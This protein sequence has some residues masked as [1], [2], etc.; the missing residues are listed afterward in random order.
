M[1]DSDSTVLYERRDAVAIITMNRPQQRNAMNAAMCE[2][3]RQ[4]LQRFEEDAGARAAVLTGAGE[5][6]FCAGLDL[7]AYAAGEGPAIIEGPGGFGGL[8]RGQPAKPVVAAVNGAAVGGGLELVLACDLAVAAANA[9]FSSPEVT[10]GLF[11]AAGGAFRLVRAVGRARAME[12]LLTGLTIDARQ[13][14]EWGLVNT[15]VPPTRLVGTA[16]SLAGRAGSGAP[17]GVAETLKLARAAFDRDEE[18]LWAMSDQGWRRVADSEDAAEGPRAF[19]EKREP[20]WTG[21]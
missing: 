19:V 12:M 10:V 3:L 9:R 13:A 21:R 7:K 2:E 20:R 6:A 15:V 5:A 8:V 16:V 18:A 14:L 1:P 17:L 11:A 4:A